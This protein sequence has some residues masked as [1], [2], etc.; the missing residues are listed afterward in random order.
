MNRAALLE[1]GRR[2]QV[3]FND[4]ILGGRDTEA[5]QLFQ[6]YQATIVALHGSKSGSF[7]DEHSGG[8][9]LARYCAAPPGTAPGWGQDGRF[10]IEVDGVHA[11]AAVT[12]WLSG[13]TTHVEFHAVDR[14][15]P[16]ISAT[17]YRSDWIRS[18]VAGHTLADVVRARF[19]EHI[20]TGLCPVTAEL[21]PLERFDWLDPATLPR[22]TAPVTTPQQ[23]GFGF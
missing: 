18:P 16:F 11:V 10:F 4:A 21:H 9:I 8:V 5:D 12:W 14:H 23:A 2:A 1:Q 6:S 17:G 7:A 19:Q 22:Q 13:W 3:A 20:N 15:W